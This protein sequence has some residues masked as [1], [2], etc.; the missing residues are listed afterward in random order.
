MIGQTLSQYKVIEKLGEGGM[1][2]VYKAHDTKLDRFVALKFLPQELTAN[3]TERARFLQEARA[4]ATLNHPN[5]CT[6][7]DIRE[8]AGQ[9]FI[10]M[11]YVDGKTLRSLQLES[12]KLETIL[13]YAIQIGEALQEAHSKG[14]V[15]RDIKPDNIM[16]NSRNQIKVMDFGLAKLKGSMKLTRTS[17]TVGTLSYMAPE[18]IQG[19]EVD[20]R[21]DIFSF[22]VVLYE[23]LCGRTPFPGEHEAAVVYSIVNE[24]PQPVNTYR[25]EVSPVL[26]NLVHRALEKDPGDRYQS[27]S[28][29][30]I[31]LR[32]MQKQTTKV[33]RSQAYTVTSASQ[34][35]ELPHPVFAPS[36]PAG[37]RSSKRIAAAGIGIA[38][39]AV[40]IYLIVAYFHKPAPNGPL[41]LSFKQL[42]DQRE[43]AINP[44]I[45]PNGDFLV[46]EE[47]ADTS[48]T[49]SI[50][51]E[52]IGG[53][54]P[55]NLTPD[56]KE[57]NG[58]P[59]YSPDGQLI[60]FRSSRDHGG[61]YLMGA[62]GENVRRLSDIGFNPCWSPDGKKITVATE[63]IYDPNSRSTTS[64]LWTIDVAT[65]EKQKIKSG[66]AVQP[67]WSPHGYRIAYW[68]WHA[69]GQR[70]IWT[71]PSGGGDSVA[72]TY[73]AYVDW[74]PIWSPDGKYL[75]F[76]SDRGGSMNLW[77]VPIDE[78]TGK[79]LGDPQPVTTPSAYSGFVCI[80][81]D[82]LHLIYSAVDERVNLYSIG[83]D[84]VAEAFTG[85]E[86][87]L[88]R[89][90]KVIAGFSVSSD[91]NWI[92]FT[93]FGGQEDVFVIKKDGSGLRQ[94]TNDL[95]KDRS[96]IWSSDGKKLAFMSDR[97]GKYEIWTI[98][99]D[100][101]DL[102]Q[103]TKTSSLSYIMPLFWFRNGKKM[104]CSGDS[105]AEI[106]DLTK[107]PS[108][109]SMERFPA[110]AV[111]SG[112]FLWGTVSPNEEMIAGSTSSD[113][114][115]GIVLYSFRTGA[116]EAVVDSGDAPAWLSDNRRLLFSRHGKTFI[117]DIQTK[118]KHEVANF[119]AGV[120]TGAFQISSDNRTF[121][122][123]V[124]TKEA[125]L[126]E[127]DIRPQQ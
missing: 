60:A 64:E 25:P 14:L 102:E 89:G 4:A 41:Q 38:L 65:G 94:L 105:G 39:L 47:E 50:Y 43:I 74:R 52:R 95:A 96:V 11:E 16:V 37:G 46:Y 77:R 7:Y 103:L 116:Y 67:Q 58:E 122:Y 26:A 44:D 62:T 72:V 28:D 83:F 31:E 113:S 76:C 79:T 80:S 66:D 53:G 17:S 87:A 114:L 10:V 70:D 55:I 51:L 23:M 120:L 24:E 91:D 12:L 21:S 45:S 36:A 127:G 88:T 68:N 121:Y 119:P 110:V 22:G 108:D 15:H 97:G 42:T 59:A 100:G 30:V 104:I 109:K 61:I 35:H 93:T 48:G 27:V 56:S 6:I 125:N 69:G 40:L 78:Q 63:G 29:M 3:D 71:I 117:V 90:S 86:T 126:W 82:G 101:S 115:P 84:P 13:T 54:N 107:P 75:F 32:R 92:S 118:K 33:V 9:Q 106:C 112:R 98:N 19:G 123:E 124:G 5:V 34:S 1:G 8:D 73:D 2:V 49:S 99:A 111:D 85:H 20:A 18:Q 81:R 57:Y